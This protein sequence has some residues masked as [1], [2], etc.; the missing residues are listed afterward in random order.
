MILDFGS[1]YFTQI[2]HLI[3][4]KSF[5]AVHEYPIEEPTDFT[6]ME[7]ILL[8]EELIGRGANNPTAA[9]NHNKISIHSNHSKTEDD[10]TS[11]M[12]TS[13]ISISES[14]KAILKGDRIPE[15]TEEYQEKFSLS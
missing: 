6:H 14:V 8:K 5:G 9:D 1:I 15:L 10:C 4:R 2:T 11:S 12:L 13:N 3:I 7:K